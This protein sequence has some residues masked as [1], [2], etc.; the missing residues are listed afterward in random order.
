MHIP[1]LFALLKRLIRKKDTVKQGFP[2]LDLPL[3]LVY[4]I[5]DELKLPEKILLSQTCRLLR[6]TLHRKCAS[7]MCRATAHKRLEYL[8]VLGHTL[9]D[10]RLCTSCRALHLLNYEDIPAMKSGKINNSCP[11]PRVLGS[12]HHMLPCY[13][14]SFHHVQL[15]IKYT[16]LKNFHQ[17]YREKILQ[18]FQVKIPRFCSVPLVFSAIPVVVY[19][20]FLLM[21]VFHF[22]NAVEPTPSSTI[23]EAPVRICP[24][25]GTG[26]YMS[27]N[28]LLAAVR[29][30]RT[31]S[32]RG[33]RGKL[34]SCDQCPTE[35]RVFTYDRDVTLRVWQDLGSGISPTD[36]Y[37]CSHIPS[38][39]N[40][41]YR[42][43]K[44]DYEHGS[45]V[46]S[47]YKGTP[48]LAKSRL[49]DIISISRCLG[50]Y[51]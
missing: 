15:A 37:W 3:D 35:F 5:I 27:N 24:H 23:F 1:W 6:Y 34:Y 14:I 39:N 45:I 28:P 2:L 44:F 19:G 21:T 32:R 48:L 42:G 43:T 38:V 25:L 16:R 41:L 7:T 36:P 51:T 26:L 29:L 40:S 8:A 12:R 11:V 20:R 31:E 49:C 46:D 17:E 22:Y 18:T 50:V 9:P 10:H 33:R 30:A 4:N 47:F 13:S